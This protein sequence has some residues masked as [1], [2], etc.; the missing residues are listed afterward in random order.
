MKKKG[1]VKYK[2]FHSKNLSSELEMSKSLFN[3]DQILISLN[4]F[5]ESVKYTKSWLRSE[6][7]KIVYL[8][9]PISTY[10]WDDPYVFLRY[11]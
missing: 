5:F 11:G 4:V 2:P 8:P 9:S 1:D 3:Q 10:K 6:N 7:I